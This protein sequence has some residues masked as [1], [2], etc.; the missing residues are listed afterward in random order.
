HNAH[1]FIQQKTTCTITVTHL[2]DDLESERCEQLRLVVLGLDEVSK[3]GGL[4]L[5]LEKRLGNALSGLLGGVLDTVVGLHSVEEVNTASRGLDVLKTDVD[6]LGDN[7]GSTTLVDDDSDSVL[8]HVEHTSGTAVVNLVGHTLL[9]GTVALDVN[10][11]STAVD[12][13][14]G[15]EMLNTVLAEVTGEHVARSA[16]DTLGVDHI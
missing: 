10:D 14:V 15:G 6:A 5:T 9:E 1:I 13:V 8:G 12:A 11:I 7:A 4:R 2:G 16:P 3:G